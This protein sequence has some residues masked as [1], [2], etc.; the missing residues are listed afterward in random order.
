MKHVL[1]IDDDDS[2]RALI[3]EFLEDAGYGVTVMGDGAS[4]LREIAEHRPDVV[5]LDLT[6]PDMSGLQ[7][8]DRLEQHPAPPPVIAASGS[9]PEP[10]GLRSHACVRAY[11][12][13]PFRAGELTDA[14]ALL[15]SAEGG[16]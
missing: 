2:L 11:L 16:G 12:S 14:I 3:Q 5:L 13:K 1:V 4:G 8:L 10:A 6:L 9:G 15:R 7:L